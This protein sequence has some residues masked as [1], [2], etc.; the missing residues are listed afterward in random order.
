MKEYLPEGRLLATEEN[1]QA[2]GSA[3]GLYAAWM[4][5][6]L[7]EGMAVRCDP[8]HGLWVEL[9]PWLGRIPREEGAL[10]IR[11][12]TTRDIA[13]MTRVGKPVCCYIQSLEGTEGDLVPRLSRRAA[14]EE[15]L[16]HLLS[17]RPGSVLPATVTRL[18][19]FGA[20]VDV[21]CGVASLV[22]LEAISVSRIPHPAAR[23]TLGE[24]INVLLTGQD[25]EKGRIYLSHRELLGTW[26]E[27][28]A[29]FQV[30]ETVPGIVRSVQD[31]GAFV[32]LTP[33]LSGLTEPS[34]GLSPG[35]RVAVCIKAILPEKRKIKL[36]LI[37]TA[38]DTAA[39]APPHYFIQ[40]GFLPRWQYAP[41]GCRR[42][43]PVWDCTNLTPRP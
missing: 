31:Y 13:L 4:G 20:F 8:D 21:G 15:A 7:V 14:Q 33:N 32:E 42:P 6:R 29:Q 16:A 5:H 22:P 11:E 40:S 3:E 2:V 28:A 26:A 39:P 27:N 18:E 38:E 17:L 30:G 24:Q 25:G 35:G 36:S 23:F 43:G 1:R 37:G 19:R 12:G 10:G 41:E 34:E 9:G